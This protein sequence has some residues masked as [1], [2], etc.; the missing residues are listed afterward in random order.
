MS[1]PAAHQTHKNHKVEQIV[2]VLRKRKLS[3][4]FMSILKAA[5]HNPLLIPLARYKHHFHF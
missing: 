4:I 1:E 5:S 3:A 2:D